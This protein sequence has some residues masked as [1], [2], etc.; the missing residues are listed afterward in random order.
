MV[1]SIGFAA[2]ADAAAAAAGFGGNAF[3]ALGIFGFLSVYHVI[4][5]HQTILFIVSTR[6]IPTTHIGVPALTLC[7]VR[8]AFVVFADLS[9]RTIGIRRAATRFF[10]AH[11]VFDSA[12]RAKNP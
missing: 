6:T 1:K 9:T 5:T 3:R 11:V 7:T 12:A 2:A 4:G 8:L 10:L